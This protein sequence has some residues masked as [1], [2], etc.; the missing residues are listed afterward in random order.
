LV[1]PSATDAAPS[2]FEALSGA[3]NRGW[4]P[5][6][7]VVDRGLKYID[8]PIPELYDLAADP[9]EEHNLADARSAD[10]RRLASLVAAVP[11]QAPR[12]SSE[13]PGT[14]DRLRS[15]GYASGRASIKDRYTEADDPKRLIGIDR[16]LQRIVGLYLDGNGPA[17]LAAA[18]ALTDSHP[19]MPMAWLQLAHLEREGGNLAR[20]VDALE[21]AHTLNPSNTETTALLGGYLTQAGRPRDAVALLVPYAAHTNADVDVLKT[22]A[23]ARAR[24]GAADE[25]LAVLHRAR[26][27]DPDSP[28]LLI[29][30]GTVLLTAG[31]RAA[32]RT[33]FEQALARD[34]GSARAQSS[35]GAIAVEDGRFD[36]A[37]VHWR[38]A[39]ARDSAEFAPIFA[40]GVAFARGGHP[41]QA[42]ACL[43]FFA[44]AAPPA[45]YGPQI[46]QAR[47]WLA[48]AR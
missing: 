48:G 18:R 5:L 40:L 24:L 39:V 12:P 8:L 21:R 36:E 38:A 11:N 19:K 7:G 2:Y 1:A 25:A 43:Q 26:E 6:R 42:R 3:L 20:A 14:A 47:A 34:P 17:V 4:A 16:E 23:L 33:A 29:D 37:A 35:L 32:A 9:R 22:L 41:G 45:R 10:V 44:D 27:Q 31:R 13:D 28:E 46:A 30:E 15:L